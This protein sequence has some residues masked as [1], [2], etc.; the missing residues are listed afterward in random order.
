MYST[1][2]SLFVYGFRVHIPTEKETD[3]KRE[4]EKERDMRTAHTE[5]NPKLSA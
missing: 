5:Y 1:Y 2:M 4:R 3:R